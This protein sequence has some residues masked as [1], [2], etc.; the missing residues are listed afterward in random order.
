MNFSSTV[1]FILIGLHTCQ[2]FSVGLLP[3]VLM[4]WLVNCTH[5]LEAHYRG[6]KFQSQFHMLHAVQFQQFYSFFNISNFAL[7]T[8]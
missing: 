8:K 7:L 6:P 3:H 2:G 4:C 5:S 1:Y